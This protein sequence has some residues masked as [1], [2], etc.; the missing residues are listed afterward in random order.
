MSDPRH[1]TLLEVSSAELHVVYAM[2]ARCEG[3]F[4]NEALQA[5]R[6]AIFLAVAGG[7]SFKGY[8]DDAI[9]A[10]LLA[11]CLLEHAEGPDL[12]ASILA[13]ELVERVTAAL[14]ADGRTIAELSPPSLRRRRA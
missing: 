12:A 6:S 5:L 2:T 11:V 13:A 4:N 1:M 14:A 8:F 7:G 3:V 10:T 9:A